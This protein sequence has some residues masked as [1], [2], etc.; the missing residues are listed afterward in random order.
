MTTEYLKRVQSADVWDI[1]NPIYQ[2]QHCK[3]WMWFG[4]IKG[5]LNP[6]S[7]PNQS[8]YYVVWKERSS[9]LYFLCLLMSSFSFILEEIKEVFI[10]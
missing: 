4:E 8:F 6:N 2:C 3:A 5:L 10:F 7:R 9:F 1:E